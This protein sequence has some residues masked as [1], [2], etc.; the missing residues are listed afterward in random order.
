MQRAASHW[1]VYWWD[2]ALGLPDPERAGTLAMQYQKLFSMCIFGSLACFMRASV[3]LAVA[4][5][6]N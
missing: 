2:I 6:H 3:L 1:S 5:T 4:L